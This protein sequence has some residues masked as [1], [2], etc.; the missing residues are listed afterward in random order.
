MLIVLYSFIYILLIA[1]LLH[2]LSRIL[3]WIYQNSPIYVCAH[4]QP[5]FLLLDLL[6]VFALEQPFN[7]II[8]SSFLEFLFLF[9]NL[10]SLTYFPFLKILPILLSTTLSYVRGFAI[11]NLQK[12]I[13]SNVIHLLDNQVHLFSCL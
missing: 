9:P 2:K 4:Q 7:L 11:Y 12:P 10:L 13:L 1:F 5:P 3:H 6:M 8:I